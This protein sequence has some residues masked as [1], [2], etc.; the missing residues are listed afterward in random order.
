MNGGGEKSLEKQKL[1]SDEFNQKT[2]QLLALI[3]PLLASF[4]LRLSSHQFS[5]SR[6]TSAAFLLTV[7]T[8]SPGLAAHS[9]WATGAS[10][11][12]YCYIG[13]T[14]VICSSLEPGTEPKALR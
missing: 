6:G 9:P 14:W 2:E 10:Q 1:N 12:M 7:L 11:N 8:D 3:S 13:Q 5:K 4:L